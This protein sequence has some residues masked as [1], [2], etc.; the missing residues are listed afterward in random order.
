MGF[1]SDIEKYSPWGYILELVVF[2]YCVMG[3]SMVCDDYLI[4]SIEKICEK[5]KI[6]AQVA[7]ATFMAQEQNM[8][9]GSP[10]QAHK[11]EISLI[12]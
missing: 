3:I 5:L 4:P 6:S 12:L 11:S 1:W 9:T 2:C 8:C 10:G 7:G